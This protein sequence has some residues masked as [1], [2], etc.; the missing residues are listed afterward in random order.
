M[1]QADSTADSEV[2]EWSVR[3][4]SKQ[5]ELGGSF[6]VYIFLGQVPADPKHWLT[7]PAFAGTF[8]VFSNTEPDECANCR[9]QKDLVIKGFVHLNRQILKRSGNPSLKPDVVLPFLKRELNWGI[10]K[11]GNID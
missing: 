4:Q 6:S 10:K 3:V 2:L 8:D 7:D 5:F 1:P 9:E 11:V